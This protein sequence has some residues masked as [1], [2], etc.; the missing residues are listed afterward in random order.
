MRVK[1]QQAVGGATC[2]R[3]ERRLTTQKRTCSCCSKVGPVACQCMSQARTDCLGRAHA[4]HMKAG[5]PK[6]QRP[7]PTKQNRA[8]GREGTREKSKDAEAKR[9]E[10]QIETK[11]RSTRSKEPKE[12][13]R[14]S[15]QKAI[16]PQSQN[17]FQ[18]QGCFC[19]NLPSGP[20]ALSCTECPRTSRHEPASLK[21]S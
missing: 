5:R 11:A 10:A 17:K 13:Q 8:G 7:T 20:C 9:A 16:L 19:A 2:A 1:L 3:L 12:P 6:R 14:H 4:K 15:N 18:R 21:L